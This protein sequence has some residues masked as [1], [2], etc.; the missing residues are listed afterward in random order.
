MR[1]A[2][3]LVSVTAFELW[4]GAF[5]G[6]YALCETSGVLHW[7]LS[8]PAAVMPACCCLYAWFASRR[9]D[10]KTC[11]WLT[12]LAVPVWLCGWG[13]VAAVAGDVAQPHD[14]FEERDPQGT[15]TA[16]A[17]CWPVSALCGL[18]S[19]VWAVVLQVKSLFRPPTE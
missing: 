8:I 11:L 2:H 13:M 18:I 12:V 19:F 5:A 7:Y 3:L 1:T 6:Y 9:A 14:R 15:G 17:F 4:L 10:S 16:A